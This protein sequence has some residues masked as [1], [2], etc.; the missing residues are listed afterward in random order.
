MREERMGF[1]NWEDGQEGFNFASLQGGASLKVGDIIINAVFNTLLTILFVLFPYTP[2]F[3][4]P[5]PSFPVP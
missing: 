5:P 4:P 2:S 1:V 3:L